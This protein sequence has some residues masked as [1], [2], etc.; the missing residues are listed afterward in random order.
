MRP[1]VGR[2]APALHESAFLHGVDQTHHDVAVD[3]H[4]VGQSLLGLALAAREMHQ[5]AEVRRLHAQRRQAPGELLRAVRAELGEQEADTAGQRRTRHG[6]GAIDHVL[7]LATDIVTTSDN[8]CGGVLASWHP[9]FP[10][11][12][13]HRSPATGSAPDAA[14]R[15]E[16]WTAT[17]NPSR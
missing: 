17:P 11:S 9:S 1:P 12:A 2:V 13:P 15:E 7:M 16:P 10:A 6:V 3:A 4:G 5:Q 14:R 8:H